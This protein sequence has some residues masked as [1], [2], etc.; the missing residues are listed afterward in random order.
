[1][2][3]LCVNP[4]SCQFSS[5]HR[6]PKMLLSKGVEIQMASQELLEYSFPLSQLPGSMTR[7]IFSA[8]SHVKA[9]ETESPTERLLL[10]FLHMFI[11][12]I[13]LVCTK[14]KRGFWLSKTYSLF[15]PFLS[16][17]A[18]SWHWICKALYPFVLCF[19]VN[20]RGRDDI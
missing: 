2:H 12:T 10:F 13:F 3:E 17:N 14:H 19:I 1:M 15:T 6:P 5:L 7:K 8:L 20:D 4:L 9:E 16:L 18:F 11:C